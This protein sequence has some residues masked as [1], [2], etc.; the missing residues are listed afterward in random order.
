ML[1]LFAVMRLLGGGNMGSAGLPLHG[2]WMSTDLDLFYSCCRWVNRGLSWTCSTAAVGGVIVAYS[3]RPRL[4]E[5][6]VC[7]NCSV[8][9]ETAATMISSLCPL[10][11]LDM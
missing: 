4:L 5:C 10:Y 3:T 7:R 8:G 6:Q 1:E 11:A 2:G 9:L